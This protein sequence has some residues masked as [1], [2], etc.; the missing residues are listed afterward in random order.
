MGEKG[1]VG[2]ASK[3]AQTQRRRVREIR[4]ENLQRRAAQFDITF[5][6]YEAL[7]KMLVDDI[8]EQFA[9]TARERSRSLQILGEKEFMDALAALRTTK[10]R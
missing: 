9:G 3:V 4:T 1:E 6:Q 2:G 10:L 7:H 5:R 8:L